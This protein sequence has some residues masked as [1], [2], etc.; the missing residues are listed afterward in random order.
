MGEELNGEPIG[1]QQLQVFH[2]NVDPFNR[3]VVDGPGTGRTGDA[4]G[5]LARLSV[6]DRFAATAVVH[7]CW[8]ARRWADDHW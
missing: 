8:W 5:Y 6:H 4:G 3:D 1:D 2:V 7:A